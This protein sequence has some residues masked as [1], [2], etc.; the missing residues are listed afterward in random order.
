MTRTARKAGQFL[1]TAC[2]QRSIRAY[3]RRINGSVPFTK[4]KHAW[5][6]Q[7]RAF[8]G[9]WSARGVIAMQRD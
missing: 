5:R 4:G 3:V 8:E 2:C 1:G 7:I 6:T 9:D